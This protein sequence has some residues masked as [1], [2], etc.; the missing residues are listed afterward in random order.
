MNDDVSTADLAG[1]VLALRALAPPPA[2]PLRVAVQTFVRAR[3]GPLAERARSLFSPTGLKTLVTRG[4][5]D[6]PQVHLAPTLDE[7][8]AQRLCAADLL[9]PAPHGCGLS[10][11]ALVTEGTVPSGTAGFA[12]LRDRLALTLDDCLVPTG[13]AATVVR[14]LGGEDTARA[15]RRPPFG[16]GDRVWAAK[17][18]AH[19]GPADTAALRIDPAR[20][21]GA[22]GVA[23]ALRSGAVAAAMLKRAPLEQWVAESR[24]RREDFA[25][26]APSAAA[27][28][29]GAAPRKPLLKQ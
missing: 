7:L 13:R 12:A 10:L 29:G 9:A 3:D 18:A 28:G 14:L 26:I 21:L 16:L 25:R 27:G 22:E 24:W 20:W 5:F 17:Y 8:V 11:D 23:E 19:L 6:G 4:S 15:L 1:R 2:H